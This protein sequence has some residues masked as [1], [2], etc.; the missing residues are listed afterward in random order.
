MGDKKTDYQI[1]RLRG[2]L[3]AIALVLLGAVLVLASNVL[4][5]QRA[6]LATQN[7]QVQ[8]QTVKESPL[9][10]DEPESEACI[11][12]EVILKNPTSRELVEGPQGATGEKGDTGAQGL[13]GPTGP[14][15]PQGPKGDKGDQGF[16]GPQGFQGLTGLMGLNGAQGPEGPVGPIGPMGPEG[17]A[18]PAGPMGPMGPEGPAGITPLPDSVSLIC[19][20]GNGTITITFKDGTV[21]TGP[22]Q[23]VCPTVP[24]ITL[25]D[26]PEAIIE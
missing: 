5:A 8:A 14:M 25:P 21:A 16:T 13:R 11:Q 7:A 6:D 3:P 1:L 2:L 17:P 22:A 15:G 4:S 23:G 26:N 19:E 24:G 18:G 10:T 9:C 12:S 20:A